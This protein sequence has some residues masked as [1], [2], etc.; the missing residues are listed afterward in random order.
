MYFAAD[1]IFPG[2]ISVNM[3]SQEAFKARLLPILKER[4]E[5]Y[6]KFLPVLAREARTGEKIYSYTAD[7]LE[8]ENIAEE[9]DFIVRNQTE[10]GEEYLMG[11][12]KF[13]RKYLYMEPAGEG[14]ARYQ[15]LGKAW[16]VEMTAGLARELGFPLPF[17]FLAS[18]GAPMI[19]KEND[20]LVCSPRFSSVYRIARKEFFETY[21]KV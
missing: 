11:S 17:E 12:E 6:K 14:M 3:L 5:L 10:A 21:R 7:G 18:W 1:A 13:H 2:N 9:G 8:T 4:G 16:A 19:V 20:F 15:P